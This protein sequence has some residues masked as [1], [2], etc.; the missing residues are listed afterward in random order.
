[1]QW[2]SRSVPDAAIDFLTSKVSRIFPFHRR[3]GYDIAGHKRFYISLL[4]LGGTE[5][6]PFH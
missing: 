6:Q 2:R 3:F 4:K 1:M 5:G